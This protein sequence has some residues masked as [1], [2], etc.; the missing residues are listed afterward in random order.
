VLPGRKTMGL[1]NG[2]LFLG[3][4]SGCRGLLRGSANEVTTIR[5][6]KGSAG[7]S[8][9]A[10]QSAGKKKGNVFGDAQMRRRKIGQRPRGKEKTE[11]VAV[12]K[13]AASLRENGSFSIIRPLKK[14]TPILWILIV[15]NPRDGRRKRERRRSTEEGRGKRGRKK[16][17]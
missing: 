5:G 15:R 11:K 9:T 3:P 1:G 7:K 13:R 10:S 8:I 16:V 2:E 12:A 4:D 14:K 6:K 17:Q